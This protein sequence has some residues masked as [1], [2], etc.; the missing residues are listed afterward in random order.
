MSPGL[1]PGTER[2]CPPTPQGGGPTRLH[3]EPCPQ[4]REAR[5]E[6]AATAGRPVD[7]LQG[8]EAVPEASVPGLARGRARS[9]T[10]RL[11]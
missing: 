6:L 4:V 5:G 9:S 3:I 10:V 2:G 11:G 1:R 7:A 8:L